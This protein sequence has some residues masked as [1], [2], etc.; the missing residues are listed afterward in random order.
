MNPIN[1]SFKE[2]RQICKNE[3]IEI[4]AV[5]IA[6][7]FN[8]ITKPIIEAMK[9]SSPMAFCL[10]DLFADKLKGICIAS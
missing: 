1:S 6:D 7:I 3:I 5:L 2:A 4:G 10:G 8:R 9:P